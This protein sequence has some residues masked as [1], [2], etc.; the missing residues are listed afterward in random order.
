MV[1][2]GNTLLEMSAPGDLSC[3]QTGPCFTHISYLI[4]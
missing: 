2:H 3:G 4:P 1:I